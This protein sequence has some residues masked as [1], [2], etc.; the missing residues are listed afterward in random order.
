[1]QTRWR[2]AHSDMRIYRKKMRSSASDNQP[3]I[4]FQIGFQILN[5]WLCLK[6]QGKNLTSFFKDNFIQSVAIYG[7]G[8]LGERFY[9][10]M[11]DTDITIVYTIDRLAALKTKF[12]LKIYSTDE[13]TFP[14]VDA[15]V[16]TPVR[17]YWSIVKL[18]EEKIDV[19]IISLKDIVDYCATG[20]WE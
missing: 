17:D 3:G 5:Q 20:G 15:I 19:P 12:D 18:L 8:T 6:Q 1:M 7:M 14:V 13:D 10:E 2:R 4:G 9:E 16:V 11:C